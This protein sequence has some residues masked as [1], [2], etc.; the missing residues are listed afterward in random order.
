MCC[1][2]QVTA[3][4]TSAEALRH[5]LPA[6]A[7]QEGQVHVDL[8]IKEHEPNAGADAGRLLRRMARDELLR[9]IPVVGRRQSVGQGAGWADLIFVHCHADICH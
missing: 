9:R 7:E 2:P 4:K 5:L 8:V 1:V 3:V 6:T